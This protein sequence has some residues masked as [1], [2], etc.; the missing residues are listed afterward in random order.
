MKTTDLATTLKEPLSEENAADHMGAIIHD[1]RIPAYMIAQ[2]LGIPEKNLSRITLRQHKPRRDTLRQLE[3]I[4]KLV[5][6]AL[7]TL[8]P[9]G[10]FEWLIAPNPFLNDVA[11]IQCLR[12]EKELEK[13][14]GVLAAIKFGF[15]A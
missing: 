7:R 2:G 3:R 6:D 5:Q 14:L 12:S 8:T 4:Q 11:P 1:A 13:V 9:K 15:P 10:A